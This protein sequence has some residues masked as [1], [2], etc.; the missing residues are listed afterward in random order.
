MTEQGIHKTMP[1]PIMLK[2]IENQTKKKSKSY[3][4]NQ[5]VIDTITQVIL[6]QKVARGPRHD[7]KDAIPT[8]RKAS[9]YKPIGFSLDKAFDSENIHKIIHEELKANSMI[10]AKKRIKK[11]KYRL[12]SQS[13]FNKKQ[14]NRRNP[15]ETVISVLKRVFGDKNQSRS[16]RLRN[17]ETK[18]RNNCYNIYLHAKRLESVS[19]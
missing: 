19:F 9:K 2:K 14:Y 11:G 4:K 10:P 17:K 16:D 1:A 7:S 3:S 13:L 5:I 12:S 15:S 8:I 6:A 18:H